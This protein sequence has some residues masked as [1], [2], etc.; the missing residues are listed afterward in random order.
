[1]NISRL[2]PIKIIVLPDWI[3]RSLIIN[4][5]DLQA[6]TE[7]DKIKSI[8]SLYDMAGWLYLNAKYQLDKS[9]LSSTNAE[10]TFKDLTLE[11]KLELEKSVL[12]LSGTED[13]A[14]SMLERLT[15][16]GHIDNKCY[17]FI[18]TADTIFVI[19]FPGF[20]NTMS[21]SN[22]KLEFIR[23]YLKECY[24]IM[25]ISVVSSVSLFS[26]YIKSL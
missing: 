12:P 14:K 16:E 25:P 9:Y 18:T 7:Y 11:Q 6:L 21:D 15:S 8:M 3:H 22:K 17:N 10:F 5:L 20:I 1:M 24:K 4:N 26:L 13:I 2:S 19:V 23:D